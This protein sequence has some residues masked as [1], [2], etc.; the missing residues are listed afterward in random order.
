MEPTG[1]EKEFV[2][3]YQDEL[4]M[5]QSMRKLGFDLIN[6]SDDGVTIKSASE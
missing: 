6:K 5:L 4:V 1:D 3:V 2:P